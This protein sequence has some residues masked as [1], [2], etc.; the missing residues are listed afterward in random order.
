MCYNAHQNDQIKIIPARPRERSKSFFHG[1]FFFSKLL[2]KTV[3]HLYSRWNNRKVR[4]VKLFERV[5]LGSIIGGI[6]IIL[7]SILWIAIDMGPHRHPSSKAPEPRGGYAVMHTIKTSDGTTCVYM[8][9][10]TDEGHVGVVGVGANLPYTGLYV[11]LD[12][13]ATP[14]S[15]TNFKGSH[16]RGSKLDPVTGIETAVSPRISAE[17]ARKAVD[18]GFD[19]TTDPARIPEQSD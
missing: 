7:L 14:L 4:S 8:R 15:P 9:F 11:S 13:G 1:G 2:Q 6:V 3:Y 5:F 17:C 18:I 16:F 12:F 19:T 10:E